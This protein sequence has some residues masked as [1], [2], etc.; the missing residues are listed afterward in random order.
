MEEV[1]VPAI[2]FEVTAMDICGP[3]PRTTGGNRYFLIFVDHLTHYPEAVPIKQMTAEEC[4]RAYDTHII[5]R[6]SSVSKLITDQGRNFTSEFFWETCKILGIRQIFTTAYHPQA[7]GIL[8]HWHKTISESLSHYA[9]AN[10]NIWDTM[11]PFS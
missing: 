2:P 9:N 10:G 7:N 4:A 3:F 6:H 1:S 5:A 8:E 11:V